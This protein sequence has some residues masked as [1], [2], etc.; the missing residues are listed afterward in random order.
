[1]KFLSLALAAWTFPVTP[2]SEQLE[3]D[4]LA[5]QAAKVDVVTLD[6]AKCVAEKI[7]GHVPRDDEKGDR[8]KAALYL[9]SGPIKSLAQMAIV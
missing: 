9:G 5:V 6:F 7:R 1:M 4:V 8:G 3:K 2:G